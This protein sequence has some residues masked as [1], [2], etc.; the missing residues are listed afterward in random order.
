MEELID[1]LPEPSELARKL[2]TG[3]W[4]SPNGANNMARPVTAASVKLEIRLPHIN[5]QGTPEEVRPVWLASDP[6]AMIQNAFNNHDYRGNS[7]PTSQKEPEIYRVL[8]EF[9]STKYFSDRSHHLFSLDFK[10]CSASKEELEEYLKVN[11][12]QDY[13]GTMLEENKLV[14][15]QPAYEPVQRKEPKEEPHDLL[16]EEQIP[17]PERLKA[18]GKVDRTDQPPPK[19]TQVCRSIRRER[20]AFVCTVTDSCAE[21]KKRSAAE[22]LVQSLQS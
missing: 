21:T 6:A 15:V 12:W 7:F 11:K 22:E 8:K 20:A 19:G 9:G 18:E 5:E 1:I 3:G 17:G 16:E 10:K 4:L 14:K 2:Y 13:Q